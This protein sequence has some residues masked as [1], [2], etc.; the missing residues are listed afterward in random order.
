MDSNLI[1]KCRQEGV[2]GSVLLD[3]QVESHERHRV[4]FCALQV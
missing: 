3:G 1:K 4:D 2:E